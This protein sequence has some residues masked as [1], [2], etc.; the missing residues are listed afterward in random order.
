MAE[1]DLA[2][3]VNSDVPVSDTPV[4]STEPASDYDFDDASVRAESQVTATPAEPAVPVE[5]TPPGAAP[6]A[7]TPPAS[8][9]LYTDQQLQRAQAIGLAPEQLAS[10]KDPETGL[11]MAENVAWRTYHNTLAQQQAAYTQQQQFA[12]QR[13]QVQVPQPPAPP[14]ALDENAVRKAWTDA[15]YEPAHAEMQVNIAREIHAAKMATHQQALNNFQMQQWA[16]QAYQHQTGL[17]QQLV[18]QQQAHQ[19]ELIGRDFNEFKLAQAENVRG[20]IDAGAQQRIYAVAHAIGSQLV[21][22]G[23]PVPDNKALFTQA[24]YATLGEKIVSTLSTQATDKVRQEVKQHQGRSIP[25]PTAAGK[26][27]TPKGGELEAA[28][29]VADQWYTKMGLGTNG[30]GFSNQ[31]V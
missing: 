12:Q 24:M 1:G 30:S 15:G 20:L 11:L 21:A 8:G 4:S 22:S 19:A 10:F 7:A 5:A 6:G 17:Q 27:P 9:A 28:G 29:R 14:P 31:D 18:A 25:R 13:Q 16:A 26:A 3:V 2:E 23:Q